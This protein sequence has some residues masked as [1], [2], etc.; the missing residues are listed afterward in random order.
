[1][2][3]HNRADVCHGGGGAENETRI[4]H[5]IGSLIRAIQGDAIGQLQ[6]RAAIAAALAFFSESYFLGST[7]D[8]M[9][10][11]TTPKCVLPSLPRYEYDV[12]AVSS[13]S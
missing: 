6:P 12:I 5:A 4:A 2:K 3:T 7:D 9:R 10:Q 1:V 8:G 13:F 11:R